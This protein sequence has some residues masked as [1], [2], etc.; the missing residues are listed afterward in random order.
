MSSF[1]VILEINADKT[2]LFH[3]HADRRAKNALMVSLFTMS[4][5]ISIT[6]QI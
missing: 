5:S 3:T 2:V 4:K 1:V 6:E